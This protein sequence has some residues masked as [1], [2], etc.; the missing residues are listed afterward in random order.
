MRGAG[1]G[2][3]LGLRANLAQFSLLVGVNALVG[4]MVGQE[5]TVVPLLARD[6]FHLGLHQVQT[7]I[8]VMLVFTGQATVYV[9]R[10]RGH[11]WTSRPG[12]WLLLATTGDAV[13]VSSF[14]SGG[15]LMT[16]V[17]PLLVLLLFG[18]AT[19]T[20]LVMDRLKVPVLR[21][22]DFF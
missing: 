18:I 12:G 22:L 1:P 7:L 15:L 5:R 10:E 11:F 13:I 19:A 4:G 8:F 17:S 21:R 9:V 6:V 14:A 2:P 3:S 16:A 20:M